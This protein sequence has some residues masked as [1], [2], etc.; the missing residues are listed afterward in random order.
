MHQSRAFLSLAL[1]TP[2]LL[3]VW[4]PA[5]NA[6]QNYSTNGTTGNCAGCHGDFTATPYISLVDGANWGNSLHNIHRSN[7]LASDCDTCHSSGSRSP[8]S[9]SS[10]VGGTGLAPLSCLGCHGRTETGGSVTGAGLRQHHWTSGVTT[11]G[12]AGC[13]SDANPA[14]YTPVGE[15]VLP[16][17]YAAPIP[18]ANHPNKPT[19]SCNPAGEEDFAGTS[20]GLDNDGDGLFDLNDNDCIPAPDINLQPGVLNFGEIPAG[21]SRTLNTAIQNVGNADLNV[22]AIALCPGTSTEFTWAPS[23]PFTLAPNTSRTLGVTYA[24]VDS[25]IDSGC[26]AITSNDPDETTKQLL[27]LNRAGSIFQFLPAIIQPNQG[28]AP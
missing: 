5:A 26:L 6:Y 2:V 14:A 21:N 19:D 16:P 7:M 27:I 8:V 23:G 17:Y 22:T 9:L 15:N 13:H 4:I 1:L 12:T 11:C 20:I 25:G 24:P 18:D 28:Q 3:T 10:S